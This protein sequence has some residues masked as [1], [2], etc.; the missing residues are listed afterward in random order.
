[1]AALTEQ[2]LRDR[3]LAPESTTIKDEM[4]VQERPLGELLDA[5]DRAAA[6]TAAAH[7]HHGIRLTQLVPPGAGG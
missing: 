6:S 1:M 7:G 3:L 5:N 2:E 4:V